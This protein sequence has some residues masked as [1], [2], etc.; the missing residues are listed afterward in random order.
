MSFFMKTPAPDYNEGKMDISKCKIDALEKS[1]G[2]SLSEAKGL[3][4]IKRNEILH[5]VQNDIN[6]ALAAA[7]PP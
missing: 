7:L 5:F 1:K 3:A 6:F 4:T 2:V